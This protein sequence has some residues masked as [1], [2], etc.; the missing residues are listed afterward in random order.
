MFWAKVVKFQEIRL[1]V[2]KYF[3]FFNLAEFS[4]LTRNN[5]EVGLRDFA[6]DS[7]HLLHRPAM[8]CIALPKASFESFDIA[9]DT[10]AVRET[11]MPTKRSV[12]EYPERV[13]VGGHV[14]DICERKIR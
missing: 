8:R 4:A 9:G 13:V 10:F 11:G 1:I 14:L 2:T 3:L 5:E 7:T 12:S 6:R